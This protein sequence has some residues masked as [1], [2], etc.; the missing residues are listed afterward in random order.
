MRSLRLYL[1]ACAL[2]AGAPLVAGGDVA[3][4]RA[5]FPGWPEELA[6]LRLEP[7][8]LLEQDR[9]FLDADLGHVGRFEVEGG[10]A[11]LRWIERPTRRVH[12]IRDCFAGAGWT[13]VPEPDAPPLGPLGDGGWSCFRAR[14]GD[15]R[16]RVRER[17][18][19]ASG[20][21]FAE[22]S[23]WYWDAALSRTAEPAW[24]EA[25]A[26]RLGTGAPG[27]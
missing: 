26:E 10:H 18:V 19:T 16:L 14:R 5:P 3:R 25:V 1:I 4:V 11:I 12:S 20:E 9:R 6:G 7:V 24:F 15:D 8:P 13:V 2:A 21:R 23:A 17:V 27:R 22:V